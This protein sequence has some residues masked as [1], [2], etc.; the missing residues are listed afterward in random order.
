M[1]EDVL[2]KVKIGDKTLNKKMLI[3]MKKDREFYKEIWNERPHVCEECSSL[4]GDFFTSVYCSHILA[5]GAFPTLRYNKENI[6]ILCLNCHQRWEF[7]DR[8]SMKIYPKNEIIINKLK[9]NENNK[10]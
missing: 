1:K 3:R 7:G 4:L 2:S 10:D 6:N 5:K 8:K 9:Y